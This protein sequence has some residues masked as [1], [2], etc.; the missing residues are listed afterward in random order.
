MAA[1]DP[2]V[3]TD[4]D[5]MRRW[6][7]AMRCQGKRIGLVP[8]MGYLHQ[9]HIYLVKEA[10]KHSDVVVV[11]IYVNPGGSAFKFP[12]LYAFQ[13]VLD[14]GI[15]ISCSKIRDL[16]LNLLMLTLV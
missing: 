4:K 2:L 11:S 3:M 13:E 5:E 12:P 7:R 10:R 14:C 8:T 6:S 16:L 1:K 9:G 15:C